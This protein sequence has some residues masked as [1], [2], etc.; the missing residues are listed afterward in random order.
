MG[1]YYFCALPTLHVVGVT[2]LIPSSFGV[3]VHTPTV[4]LAFGHFAFV[5]VMTQTSWSRVVHHSLL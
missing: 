1:V 3:S 5:L 2:T 4:S